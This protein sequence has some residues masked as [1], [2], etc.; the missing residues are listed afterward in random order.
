MQKKFPAVR[1]MDGFMT[2]TVIS[3]LAFQINYLEYESC[4]MHQ[5]ITI[6]LLCNK[7]SVTYNNEQSTLNLLQ[8]YYKPYPNV[9]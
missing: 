7:L 3:I 8:I 1:N 4:V 2:R 6:A 9:E 5:F